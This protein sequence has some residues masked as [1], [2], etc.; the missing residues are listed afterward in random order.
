M[1]CNFIRSQSAY[2]AENSISSCVEGTFRLIYRALESLTEQYEF[3]N[4]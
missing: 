1:E 3:P 2:F 4:T